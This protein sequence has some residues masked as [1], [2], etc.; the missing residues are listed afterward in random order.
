MTP[1]Q[2]QRVKEV[3]E[4]AL[5][6]EAGERAAF[7]GQACAGDELL[8]SEVNSLLSSYDQESSFMETPAAA[9]AAHSLVKEESAALVGQQLGHYQIVRE[10]GRGGMGVVYLAQDI[11]LLRPVALKLLPAHLTSDPD[12]LRRF[13]R[14]ARAAS[15]L[16]HPNILTIH[17]IG[18][19]DGLHF[20]ATEFIDGV[21]LRERI[22]S[23]ELKPGEALV[24]TEQIAS[25]LAAAH[26]A[27]I[28]HRDIKPENVMLRLDGYV[29]VLDFGLAK[30]T[31][32]QTVRANEAHATTGVLETRS[33]I[34]MGTARYMSPEQARALPL[35]A[36]SDIWS[37]GVVLY[38]MIAG[39]APFT[40]A[41]D[42]DVMVSILEREP[43]PLAQNLP[44]V[45]PELQG[46]VS[47]A[48]RKDREERY[49]V[50]KDMLLGL[51]SLRQEL[52]FEALRLHRE[53]QYQSGED[54]VA[55]LSVPKP[56]EGSESRIA[57]EREAPGTHR[58]AHREEGSERSNRLIRFAQRRFVRWLTAVAAL[59]L[60]VAGAVTL[61]RRSLPPPRIGSAV[62]LTNDGRSKNFFHLATDGSRVYFSEDFGQTPGFAQVPTNGGEPTLIPATFLEKSGQGTLY[63]IL[64]SRSE[65]LVGK[66][67]HAGEEPTLWVMSTLGGP[68][69]RLGDL[70]GHSACWS[71]DGQR[72]AYANG[73]DLYIARSDGT[74]SRKLLT[75][76][77]DRS[78]WRLSWSPDG[79]RLRF[80]MWDMTNASSLWEVSA[81]GTSLHQLLP[82]WK[83]QLVK[84]AGR[85]TPDGRY[86]VFLVNSS[87]IQPDIWA[88]R[89]TKSLFGKVDSEPI[90]LTL[91]PMRFGP[92][93]F[94]PDGKKLFA[95]GWVPHGEP[96]RYDVISRHWEPFL[97]GISA[98]DVDF[99]R[100][101]K[102]ITYVTYPEGAL[103]R[104]RADGSQRLQLTAPGMR[105]H[106]P[107][108]S[109]DG[110][111]IAFAGQ[112]SGQPFQIYVVPAEGGKAEQLVQRN[113]GDM[114]P[115]WSPDGN[116]LVFSPVENSPCAAAIYLL[117]LKSRQVSIVP[118]SDG[119]LHPR[120]SPDGNSIIAITK[121]T[122][123]LI[124]FNIGTQR[125][126]EVFEG[127]VSDPG[128]SR[129]GR[130]VYFMNDSESD[131]LTPEI[132]S[133]VVLRLRI[134]DHKVEK[135]AS[136]AGV[137]L[138]VFSSLGLAPDDSPLVLRETNVKQLYALD[139]V[140]P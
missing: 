20:I 19:T 100:D 62:Q 83:S 139:W 38:E 126:E 119:L 82:G 17:E 115:T 69:R 117:D 44:E 108:W 45:P 124:L 58:V 106:L 80:M 10:L 28:V 74:E 56:A 85:W 99:S 101:G 128:W 57:T 75:S 129:D 33:G 43:L 123:K 136:L 42:S 93:V 109:P 47:K 105:V 22:V 135:V 81:D 103:W 15:A 68:G 79:S 98:T 55:D 7:V 70:R 26:E 63:D 35:D 121:D 30:L 3:F 36:R 71:P 96:A 134:A 120:L 137:P 34:I 110:K 78:P 140:A 49:Q 6:H 13:E 21:T 27:G 53:Q 112:A 59:S 113:C 133:G 97:S 39:C 1:E 90:Q 89:E 66:N 94:S 130:F 86:Y 131:G 60:I 102:L 91:G 52:D 29:K 107:R 125:G 54:A 31:E 24:I 92:F 64:L 18:Q 95:M 14:E 51:K 77:L 67:E 114:D 9:L 122:A 87:W 88:I 132:I 48:L 104:S 73:Q 118:G 76:P 46:I 84:W 111:Q 138:K 2:W 116:R 12:R 40:G 50:I 4:Q 72:V 5:E 25:A 61:L 65:F 41:T 8:H 37:L 11:S 127:F 23:K 32:S 16:N